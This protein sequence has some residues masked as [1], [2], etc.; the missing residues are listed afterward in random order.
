M[1][2]YEGFEFFVEDLLH[3]V[4]E[5]LLVDLQDFL[6]FLHHVH[7]E[8]ERNALALHNLLVIHQLYPL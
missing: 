3:L 1:K 5:V 2:S 4:H 6:D 7:D 8:G